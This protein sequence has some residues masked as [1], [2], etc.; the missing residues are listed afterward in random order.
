MATTRNSPTPSK[1]T[2]P[3]TARKPPVAPV[4]PAAQ[5]PAATQDIQSAVGTSRPAASI[6][7]L[8]D[9]TFG[10]SGDMVPTLQPPGIAVD[11]A[12]AV[13]A[14][15]STWQYTKTVVATWSINEPRNAWMSVS[16]L[17]WRKLFN[18]TDGAFVQLIFLAAQAR[19]TGRPISFREEADGLVHEIYLW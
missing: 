2:T 19:Q 12:A 16:G 13:G 6:A 14:V 8:S 1:G 5:P 4:A 10:G 11:D 18:G 17:G 7:E 9:I 15:T 3:V